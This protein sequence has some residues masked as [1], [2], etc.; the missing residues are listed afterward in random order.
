MSVSR[1]IWA[2]SLKGVL[3]LI[4]VLGHAIQSVYGKDVY[5]NHLWN[6]IYSFHM[7]AFFVISGFFVKPIGGG[8]FIIKRVHQLLVPY[9]IWLL[10]KT[11]VSRNVSFSDYVAE[12][13][14]PI[15]F[16][17][18]WVLFFVYTLFQISYFIHIK[19]GCSF[20]CSNI[21]FAVILLL[22]NQLVDVTAFG[23]ERICY[24]FVFFVLG[25][26]MRTYQLFTIRNKAIL[27][28]LFF[29]WFFLA[30]SWNM[31]S[32]PMWMPTYSFL[33]FGAVKLIYGIVAALMAIIVIMNMAPSVLSND[34]NINKKI[35][36]LGFYSL[37]MY[38]I[39]LLFIYRVGNIIRNLVSTKAIAVIFVFIISTLLSIAILWCLNKNKYTS[40]L[41]LG[42]L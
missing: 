5:S 31:N 10:I 24:Y 36:K 28:V 3:I 19:T 34:S 21:V 22:I 11:I 8:N 18:L 30:W 27:I 23:M 42:K 20:N 15:S 7:P 6:L 25:Y 40:R 26:Y 39:H 4:V 41:L 38:V 14:N 37:G 16:W 13:V 12:V 9:F 32:L 2:D 17:F 35:A 29:L 1:C 33:S